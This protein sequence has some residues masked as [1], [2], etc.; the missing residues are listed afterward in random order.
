MV[1]GADVKS[2]VQ[3]EQSTTTASNWVNSGQVSVKSST[4]THI[5]VTVCVAVKIGEIWGNP[6][7]A[8]ASEAKYNIS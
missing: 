1:V 8:S 2:I 5:G 3:T 6:A 4:F 7:I